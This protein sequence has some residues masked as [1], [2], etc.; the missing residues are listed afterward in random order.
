[1][2]SKSFENLILNGGYERY[3]TFEKCHNAREKKESK[4]A[5]GREVSQSIM[6]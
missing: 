6:G 3:D 5:A 2:T 4:V 1:M